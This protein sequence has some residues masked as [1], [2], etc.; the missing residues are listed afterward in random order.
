MLTSEG[1]PLQSVHRHASFLQ[2]LAATGVSTYKK[3]HAIIQAGRVKVNGKI[4]KEPTH[5]V[6]PVADEIYIHG[7]LV[8]PR[9]KHKYM[10]LNKRTSTAC[11]TILNSLDRQARWPS[12]R[13]DTCTSESEGMTHQRVFLASRL[14]SESCG[15]QLITCLLYT[16]PSPR[17]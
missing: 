4:V 8:K 16:S 10:A 7:S 14:D 12:P 2:V 17:D 15:L 9:Q 13:H 5:P 11:S 6:N 1:M 3:A